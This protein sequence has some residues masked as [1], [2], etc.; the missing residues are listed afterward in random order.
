MNIKLNS[1]FEKLKLE[2]RRGVIVLAAMSQLQ[3]EQ[4]ATR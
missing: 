2:M 1:E 4:Y 3:E